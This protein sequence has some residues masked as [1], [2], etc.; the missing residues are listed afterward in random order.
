MN[1]TEQHFISDYTRVVARIM[2]MAR[3][4]HLIDGADFIEIPK[5]F[6]AA[7][8]HWSV[9][10]PSCIAWFIVCDASVT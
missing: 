8:R 2:Q 5:I 9:T 3:A 6:F 7:Q 10:R 1:E 4:E